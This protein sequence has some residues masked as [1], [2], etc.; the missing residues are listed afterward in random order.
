MRT[1]DDSRERP[2]AQR[3]GRILR[4]MGG[5][6]GGNQVLPF[7]RLFVLQVLHRCYGLSVAE[8]ISDNGEPT[9]QNRVLDRSLRRAEEAARARM[10]GP[11]TRIVNAAIQ[12]A[13]DSGGT[14]FTVQQL[15]DR[16]G[17]ALQTFYR[18]FGSKDALMLAVV[19]EAS[20]AENERIAEKAQLAGDPLSRLRVIVMTAF[21]SANR[22]VAG[23]LGSTIARETRRLREDYA[24][25]L[26][27]LGAPFV[28]LLH[29]A[30]SAA[31][32]AGLI[33]AE[34]P[35]RDAEL[36]NEL[37]SGAFTQAVNGG[38][39]SSPLDSEAYIWRFCLRALGAEPHVLAEAGA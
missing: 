23:S 17:V 14:T 4:H 18:H 37:V 39:G 34:D 30:I 11:T 27:T 38:T 26:A 6:C 28:R 24:D 19:E 15:V 29:D 21:R 22:A 1:R 9:W 3:G 35:A 25:E 12:L 16:A 2:E 10:I 13:I 5:T 20:R 36:I 8:R 31:D 33:H 32:A 7:V